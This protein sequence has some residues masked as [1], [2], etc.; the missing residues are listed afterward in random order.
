[1][2]SQ[3]LRQDSP[4]IALQVAVYISM[5]LLEG[6]HILLQCD[7]LPTGVSS[8][9]RQLL[10]MWAGMGYR[11]CFVEI[12]LSWEGQWDLIGRSATSRLRDRV[13]VWWLQEENQ[14]GSSRRKG[15]RV[16]A[17]KHWRHCPARHL[18]KDRLICGGYCRAYSSSR[19]IVVYP[20]IHLDNGSRFY[21][22][23]DP[24][25]FV[26]GEEER[27][28][29]ASTR[30]KYRRGYLKKKAREIVTTKSI[31]SSSDTHVHFW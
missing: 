31:H 20:N 24:E 18:G 13:H 26:A 2:V 1:M 6:R 23:W 3:S 5:S 29:A 14:R 16:R 9:G 21:H 27:V 30:G 19:G 10:A 22:R 11:G 17:I 15:C 28:Q 4:R 25:T 12:L 7:H 8:R